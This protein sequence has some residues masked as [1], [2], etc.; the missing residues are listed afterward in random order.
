MKAFRKLGLVAATLCA[1]AAAGCLGQPTFKV[2]P[3][4]TRPELKTYQKMLITGLSGEMEQIL[5]GCYGR[6]FRDQSIVFV[7]RER[8]KDIFSEQDLLPDR[9]DEKTRAQ[10]RSVASVQ[11]IIYGYYDAAMQ[12]EEKV[13]TF[14]LRIVDVG[15]GEV[16]GSAIV[17]AQSE[18]GVQ[19]SAMIQRAT[20]LLKAHMQGS[21]PRKGRLGSYYGNQFG[22]P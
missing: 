13:E 1:A 5:M 2:D 10:L 18:K 19:A 11:A 22:M 8:I 7:E 21:S 9:V 16:V 14:R 6:T 20:E 17:H 15:S 4:Y 12:G 3:V